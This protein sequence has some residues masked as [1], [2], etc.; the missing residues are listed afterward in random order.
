MTY[1][2]DYGWIKTEVS[3]KHV[4]ESINTL[5]GVLHMTIDAQMAAVREEMEGGKEGKKGR[6]REGGREGERDHQQTRGKCM[7][8]YSDTKIPTR[9]D[10]IDTLQ[11]T[12]SVL[13]TKGGF[14][15]T[16]QGVE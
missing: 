9:K 4:R 11:S 16:F 10:N 2:S 3:T 14:T 8:M 13:V 12:Q 15:C 5:L 1:I 7:Y 6:E